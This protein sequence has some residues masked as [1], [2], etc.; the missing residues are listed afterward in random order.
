[1]VCIDEIIVVKENKAT[2][3]NCIVPEVGSGKLGLS[4]VIVKCL[5]RREKHT[6]STHG[7]V[8]TETRAI[9]WVM[10]LRA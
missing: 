9:I 6:F 1:M 4:S 5:E 7:S 2:K 10:I 3:D 8:A